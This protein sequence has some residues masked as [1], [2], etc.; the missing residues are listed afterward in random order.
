MSSD[1]SALLTHPQLLEGSRPTKLWGCLG[2]IDP[3][4]LKLKLEKVSEVM[5]E[6]VGLEALSDMFMICMD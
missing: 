1:D 6:N 2:R 3:S 5:M 4:L